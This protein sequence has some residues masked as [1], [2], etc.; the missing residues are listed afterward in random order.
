MSTAPAVTYYV[1]LKKQ[2]PDV[3]SAVR[4]I[5]RLLQEDEEVVRAKLLTPCFEVLRRFAKRSNADGLKGQL[6]SLGVETFIVS[7]Q[8]IRG[9][10]IIYAATASSGGGGMALRDFGDKPLYC[11]HDDIA[12]IAVLNVDTED[13][14][15]TTLI[16][17]V[18]KSTTITPR[19]DSSLF[20]FPQMLSSPGAG[21]EQF[22]KH[23]EAKTSLPVNRLFATHRDNLVALSRDFATSPSQ[24]EPPPAMQ[25]SPYDQ[26]QLRAAN[27][28]SFLLNNKA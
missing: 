17:L 5:S 22:L 13:G 15:Q 16:D 8:E 20:D 28:Y 2:R 19:L 6:N 24:V 7:D 25:V 27:L 11:P 26:R 21:V 9:H 4:P 1:V 10:L 12:E 3:G 14:K 23:L 18:R